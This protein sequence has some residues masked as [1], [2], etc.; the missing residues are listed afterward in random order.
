LRLVDGGVTAWLPNPTCR[1]CGRGLTALGAAGAAPN[2][3]PSAS[4]ASARS[5]AA[6]PLQYVIGVGDVLS[7]QFWRHSE[8]SSDVVVR[9]DGKISLLLLDDV[10]AAGSTPEELRDRIAE[11]A[12]RFFEDTQ[13]TVIV[14]EINSR[15][16]FITG[17]VA[18]PGPYALRGPMTV[19]QLIATAGG[20]L[21]YAHKDQIVIM[22][23]EDGKQTKHF[24]NYDNISRRGDAADQ[25]IE[26]KPGDTVVV[27]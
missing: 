17:M 7:V 5:A 21:E 27:P 9:P 12:D 16:V 23:V 15:L 11:K 25:N 14:K 4:A 6:T 18:K 20:L 3:G 26:L 8:V 2:R 10:D 1:L 19:L 13:V 22:R 24:F